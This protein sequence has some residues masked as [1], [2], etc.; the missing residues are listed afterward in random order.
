METL[1]VARRVLVLALASCTV[2]VASVAAQ[3]R[4]FIGTG[5]IGSAG[6]FGERI[7][8]APAPV[9][10]LFVDDGRY[11]VSG[12]TAIDTRTGRITAVMGG[13]VQTGD[14]TG[15]SLFTY[16]GQTVSVFRLDTGQLTSLI[17][18]RAP[19]LS[20]GVS[21]KYAPVARQAFVFREA[22]GG[23]PEIA[24]VAVDTGVVV[25]TLGGIWSFD[26]GWGV[27]P[28]GHRIVASTSSLLLSPGVSWPD[29]LV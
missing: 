28:D 12:T 21:V 18:A 13:A 27:S 15:P 26:Y 23:G 9:H 20:A 4:L 3:D 14:P 29:G 24:V 10:G 25:R 5:E 11:V 19:T 16:D 1:E 7:A 17:A 8:N 2:T 22:S 6:R